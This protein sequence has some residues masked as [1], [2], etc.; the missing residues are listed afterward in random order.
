MIAV[1]G[2]GGCKAGT[3]GFLLRKRKGQWQKCCKNEGKSGG[4]YPQR[5]F[6]V[7]H[8]NPNHYILKGLPTEWLH[9]KDE[10]YHSLRGPAE[11]VEVL[12]S[13]FAAKGSKETEPK[14]MVIKYGKG[15]IAHLPMANANGKSLE[16]VGFQTILARSTQ[17]AAHGKVTI[18]PPANFPGKD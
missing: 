5:E 7:K 14:I 11:N 17:F 6:L 10:L 15:T 2:W 12:A 1:G 9:A 4:H 8:D 16:C 13:S 3:S 18:N